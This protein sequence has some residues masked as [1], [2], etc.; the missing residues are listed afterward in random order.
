MPRLTTIAIAAVLAFAAI[1]D[2]TPTCETD[3][4]CEAQC[5]ADLR[6]DEDPAVC[7]VEA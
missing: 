3:T 1:H 2:E 5:R 7:E 6:P 4:D